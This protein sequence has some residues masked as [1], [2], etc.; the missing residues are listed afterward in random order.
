MLGLPEDSLPRRKKRP[1]RYEIGSRTTYHTDDT[2]A[3]IWQRDFYAA[4]D[5]TISTIQDRFDQ[6]GMKMYQMLTSIL[7]GSV[8]GSVDIPDDVAKLYEEDITFVQLKSQ[9]G[10]IQSLIKSMNSKMPQ[11]KGAFQL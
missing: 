3:E 4:I 6:K 8:T 2:L 7:M 1:E 5:C 9:L 11:V 10:I